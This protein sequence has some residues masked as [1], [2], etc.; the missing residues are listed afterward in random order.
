MR[1]PRFARNDNS[2]GEFVTFL[3]V[4]RNDINHITFEK[5]SNLTLSNTYDLIKIPIHM[6]L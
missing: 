6:V 2:T 1:L 5:G 4:V 3:P